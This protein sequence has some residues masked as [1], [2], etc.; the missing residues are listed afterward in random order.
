[1]WDKNR[2][3][4]MENNFFENLRKSVVKVI[5]AGGTGSGF[6]VKDKGVVVTNFHVVKGF[7]DVSIERQ[8][9]KRIHSRVVAVS[10]GSDVA[11]LVPQSPVD[12]P[13]LDVQKP[14]EVHLRDKLTV[15]GFPFGM[16]CSVSEGIVSS[17]D[18]L[19]GNQHY[20][21]TDAAI[22]PGNS[23]GPVFN[24]AGEV[25]G[26]ATCKFTH[27]DNVGFAMPIS[28]VIDEL[29]MVKD[30]GLSAY[31]VK[32]IS[33]SQYMSQPESN[34]PNC[35]VEL[36]EGGYF[37]EEKL[38]ALSQ[39]V[40]ESLQKLKVLPFEARLGREFWEFHQGSALVR[41]FV[42]N[43]NYLY[44]TSPL[45]SLPKEN[46]DK[47]FR[48]LLSTNT[49]PFRLGLYNSTVHVSYRAHLSDTENPVNR[50]K[51]QKNFS[52]LVIKADELDNALIKEF[53]CAPSH[54]SNLEKLGV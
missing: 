43:G 49:A 51:I 21:Q 22:N 19:I 42:Y 4:S 32:C 26:I 8:D 38:S 9:K 48:H 31:S 39:F 33:C 35:G 23:G 14:G 11:I 2:R 47:F 30:K 45:V 28:N 50:E 29:K 17:L 5:T 34:C 37:E 40:E 6:Y 24:Q 54:D 44:A 36:E 3:P 52:D 41:I 7:R 16:P 53:G 13:G 10:P 46:L 25:V 15:V 18:Q 12:V 1:M 27:A 20:I